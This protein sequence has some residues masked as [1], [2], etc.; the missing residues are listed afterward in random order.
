MKE[1]N[2]HDSSAHFLLFIK[3][4]IPAKISGLFFLYRAKKMRKVLYGSFPQ[5][6]EMMVLIF[7]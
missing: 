1:F 4:N 6:L 3:T 2:F 5:F 7:G